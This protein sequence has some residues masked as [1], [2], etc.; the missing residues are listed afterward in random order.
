M[1]LGE[2]VQITT[3]AV[4]ALLRRGI[5]LGYFGWKGDFLGAA[6]SPVSRHSGTRLQQ[7]ER[8][9]E[10]DFCLGIS[11]RLIMAKIA[12]QRRLLQRLNNTRE[13]ATAGEIAAVGER[14]SAAERAA[15][16]GELRG[17]EGVAAAR[18]F[19]L[20]SR[21]LPEAFPFERRSSRPP[22][23]AVNA[24]ISYLAAIVHAELASALHQQGLDAGVGCLH[25]TSDGRWALALDLMEPFRPTVVEALTVRLFNLGILAAGDFETREP[26][27]VYLAAGGKRKLLHQYESRVQREFFAEYLGHRTTVRKQYAAAAAAFGHALA[28]PDRFRPFRLN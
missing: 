26:G 15:S 5:P 9:R 13:R 25:A 3:Q 19:S 16:T 12:N 11:R 4:C 7:F 22:R 24:C 21:F 17:I 8:T 20:W 23:N 6:E 27:A 28:E 18:Y 1:L 10:G 14:E 2:Q